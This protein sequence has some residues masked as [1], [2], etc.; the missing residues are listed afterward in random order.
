MFGLNSWA[1]NPGD[2][3]KSKCEI[4]YEEACD[5]DPV[6]A[7]NI[8]IWDEWEKQWKSPNWDYR[9]SFDSL[10]EVF[11]DAIM[12]SKH[13]DGA[14]LDWSNT[15]FCLTWNLFCNSVEDK[16]KSIGFAVPKE[17]GAKENEEE[18]EEINKEANVEKLRKHFSISSFNRVDRFIVFNDLGARWDM[19]RD[20]A[21]KEVRKMFDVIDQFYAKRGNPLPD[22]E[23]YGSFDALVQESL[24]NCEKSGG[25]RA[26]KRYI[27]NTMLGRVLS[28]LHKDYPNVSKEVRAERRICRG[29]GRN[30]ESVSRDVDEFMEAFGK[31]AA[32]AVDP[33][34]YD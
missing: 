11:E 31:E 4:L 16:R 13:P 22:V 15:I 8:Q 9:L 14:V 19:R 34:E 24:D 7:M 28:L 25:F 26:I 21:G 17:D 29:S 30:R 18:Y 27:Q 12:T 1:R 33:T 10:S 5:A 2:S 23:Q 3:K 6:F 20:F 32:K